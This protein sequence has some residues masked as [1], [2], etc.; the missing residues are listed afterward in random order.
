MIISISTSHD[1]YD[2]W[3]LYHLFFLLNTME[4]KKNM[5]Y[6]DHRFNLYTNKYLS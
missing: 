2:L 6:H 5:C 4:I 3:H 1:G